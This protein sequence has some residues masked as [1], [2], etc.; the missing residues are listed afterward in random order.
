MAG[1][2]LSPS[3]N[4]NNENSPLLPEDDPFLTIMIY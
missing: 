1:E 2:D 3:L 4:E